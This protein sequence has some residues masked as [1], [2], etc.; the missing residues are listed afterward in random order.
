M[1]LHVTAG[2]SWWLFAAANL[3]LFLHV[4]GGTVGIISGAVALRSRKGGRSHRIAGTVFLVAMLIMATIGT[5]TSPFLP[6]P[7]MTNVAAGT[8]TF[9]LVAT[10]WVAIKRE[11]GRIGRFETGALGV[12]LGVVAAAMIF[13]FMAMNSPTGRIGKTPPEAFYVFA[14]VAAIAAAGDLKLILRGGISGSARIARHLWRMS[15]AL[16]IASGSFFLGQ[17]RIIP[18]YMR[19]S[20][21]LFVPVIAPLLLIVFWLIRVRL[22]PWFKTPRFPRGKTVPQF[23][24]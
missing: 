17:Q 5:A 11:D 4:A 9:Y 18:A 14:L 24:Q 15:A 3:I 7:S 20:P 6:V 23:S 12:A 22:M 19:G 16:T 8:L 21:W 1:I 13:I 10:G 2:S